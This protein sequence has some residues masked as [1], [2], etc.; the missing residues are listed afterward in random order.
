MALDLS[1][2]VFK[3]L[4]DGDYTLI[5]KSWELKTTT[6]TK[7]EDYVQLS[8]QIKGT[9]RVLSVNLFEKGLSIASANIIEHFGLEEMAVIDVLNH[10]VNTE[11]PA[12]HQTVMQDGKT[13]Y[14]WY[15]CSKPNF[16]TEENNGGVPA[17]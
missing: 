10:I 4:E 17:F 11:M 5:P 15:L 7:S 3:K 6:G 1:R 14:N 13:Y 8:C 2:M 12:Y 16:A 9:E